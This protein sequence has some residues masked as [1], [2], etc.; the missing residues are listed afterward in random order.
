VRRGGLDQDTPDRI[1]WAAVDIPIGG[2]LTLWA[3]ASPAGFARGLMIRDL[4]AEIVF[5]AV[6]LIA[7]GVTLSRCWPRPAP[8]EGLDETIVAPVPSATSA[9]TSSGRRF[10]GRYELLERIGEGGMAEIFAAVAF[11]SSG[12]RRF[13]VVKRL[14]AELIHN[15]EAV[16]HFIDEAILGSTLVHP[17]IVPIYDFGQIDGTYFLAEEYVLGR[18][19]GRLRRRMREKNMAP[20]SPAAVLY[21]IDQVLAAL[22]YAHGKQDEVGEPLQIVHRDVTPAN[23][24]VS[25]AGEVKLLDFGIVKTSHARLS[26]THFG[27]VNGCLEFMAPEQARSQSVDARTDLFAVGLLTFF[28][29]TAECLYRGETLIDL[30]NRAANGPGPAELERVAALPAPF[31]ELLRR[32]LSAD[33]GERFQTADEFRAFIAPHLGNGQA[34]LVAALRGAFADELQ[35]E[36]ERLTRPRTRATTKSPAAA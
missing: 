29:A 32:A 25:T 21:V 15:G 27:A 9:P 35:L 16:A 17:N 18:D 31:D 13:F 24:L 3:G 10:L 34:A 2:D 14:R 36:Q 23:V 8:E 12:F 11:G 22:A 19:L 28:A 1:P 5:W 7:A 26:Q 30:L 20:L 4:V 6:A 33:P